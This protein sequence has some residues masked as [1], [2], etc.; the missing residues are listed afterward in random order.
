MEHYFLVDIETTGTVCYS[1]DN[2]KADD[3]LEVALLEITFNGNCWIPQYSY[4]RILHSS[5]EPANK[6]AMEHM[7]ELYK[8]SNQAEKISPQ[9]V[10]QEILSFFRSC[11]ASDPRNIIL[12][13]RQAG[14]F[15]C[16]FLER[17]G[18]LSRSGDYNYRTYEQ[19][20]S[21]YFVQKLIGMEDRNALI[22][23]A[24]SIDKTIEPPKDLK[25]HR[26]LYDCFIQAKIENGLMEI[27]RR[28]QF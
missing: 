24:Q 8:L 17:D 9:A 27:I 4:S 18:I 15:D 5:R 23:F 11:G 2:S 28:W 13:G 3:I 25:P 26:A 12:I 1:E 22:R 14:S 7:Q 6:F 20:G 10:R 21:L 16:K 19:G